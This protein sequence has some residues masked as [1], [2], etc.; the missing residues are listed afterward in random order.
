[1]PCLNE[2]ETLE[3]CIRRAQK[4]MEKYAINGEIV[5][6]DNGS[7][8]GSID[9]ANKLGAKVVHVEKKGYGAALRGAIS[10]SAGKYIIMAD[11]DGS[12]NFNDLMK[13]LVP[14]RGGSDLVMGNRFLGGIEKGA[15]PL[16]NRLL[17]NPALSKIGKVLFDIP[18]SDFHCG[19]R[20]FSKSAIE[21][22]TLSS[23]GMEFASEMVIKASMNQKKIS[24]VPTTLCKDGRSRKPHLRP[25]RDGWRHLKLMLMYRPKWLFAIPGTIMGLVGLLLVA[26]LFSS[27]FYINNIGLDI[28]TMLYGACFA[29]IGLQAVVFGL[30][31]R[32]NGIIHGVLPAK[33][34]PFTDPEKPYLE[35]GSFIGA[36]LAIMGALFSAYSVF[37]W[38]QGGLQNL[39]PRESIRVSIVSVLFI[40]VGAQIIFSSFFL[41]MI[42]RKAD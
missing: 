30:A 28:N 38:Y 37:G 41:T 35:W 18:V 40:S 14:L 21:G 34:L 39:E 42:A 10:G 5:I 2:I 33:K 15:M 19:M 16:K 29:L 4:C 12:Y 24:E 17:G 6:G 13:F 3:G 1:M 31:A 22:L 36:S 20:G 8:D 11:S 32:I 27:P 25:W 26:L 23:D 9:L 7:T